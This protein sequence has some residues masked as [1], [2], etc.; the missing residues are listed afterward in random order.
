V[1]HGI[2][3]SSKAMNLQIQGDIRKLKRKLSIF[4][5]LSDSSFFSQNPLIYTPEKKKKISFFS[6]NQLTQDI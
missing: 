3:L 5:D 2:S 6:Q 1:K 4:L